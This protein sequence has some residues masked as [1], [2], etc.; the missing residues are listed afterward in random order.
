MRSFPDVRVRKV[1][2]AAQRAQRHLDEGEF[3]EARDAF[4]A[5]RAQVQKVGMPASG[6]LAWGLCVAL[7]NLGEH[8]MAMTMAIEAL[9]LDPLCPSFQRSFEVV[10]NNLRRALSDPARA[11]DDPSTPRIYQQ[12][13]AAGEADVP[14]HLAMARHLSHAGNHEGALGLLNAVTLLAPISRDAWLAREAAALAA[15]EVELAARCAAEAVAIGST[16]LPFGVPVRAA[17]EA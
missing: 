10:A 16:P 13:L 4:I 12:L 11:A 1:L 8:E 3:P 14:S 5:A 9:N 7:D 15:G 17:A 2:S 6:H